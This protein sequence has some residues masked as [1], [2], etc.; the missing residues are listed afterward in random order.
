M[1]GLL[2]KEILLQKKNIFMLLGT[3]ILTLSPVIFTAINNTDAHF[4]ICVIF[5]PVIFL[6]VGSLQ[7]NIFISDERK[8]WAFY[9]ISS[10]QNHKGQVLSKYYFSLIMSLTSVICLYICDLICS[11]ISKE[12]VNNTPIIIALFGINI[13]FN[14]VE[15]PF[16]IRFGVKYGNIFRSIFLVFL[17][18]LF[19]IYLLFGN[20]PNLN[21][22]TF[23]NQT[24]AYEFADNIFD[25][26][27]FYNYFSVFISLALYF[28]SYKLSCILYKNGID[29]Y[30][31]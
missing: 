13:F 2:Y 21:L 11:I 31:K 8:L 7:Q 24:D 30:E 14:A 16:I 29:Q 12:T 17:S 4:F 18:S 10:P 20:L 1:I 9:I 15:Y 19:V 25:K 6:I 22:E 23:F 3:I 27:T 5:Y 26:L 28:V